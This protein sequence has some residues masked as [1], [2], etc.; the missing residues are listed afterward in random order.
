MLTDSNT[1][2]FAWA[3]VPNHFHLLLRSGRVPTTVMRRLLTGHAMYF[4]RKHNRVGHL[5]QNR[6][7]SILCQ[8]DAYIL[9]L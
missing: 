8:E 5:F 2:C 6:Y 1:S 4:N 7:K 9:E 3:L